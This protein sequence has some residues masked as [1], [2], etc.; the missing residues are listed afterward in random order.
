MSDKFRDAALE[1]H[2]SNP[3][4]KLTIQP[5]KPLANQS[6]LALAYSPG[7]AAACEAIIA[8]ENAAR[9]M[10]ARGN[11][12]AVV[13]N[14]TAVLGLGNI[15]PL[16]AKPVMEGKAVLFKKFAGIDAIDI[17]VN[18]NDPHKFI[19]IVEALE[20]SFG[21]INLED[22]KAPECFIVE[23][24]LR[25]RMKIP[26]FHD[27]QHG[28]AIIVGSAVLNWSRLTGRDLSKVKVV[29]SGAGAAAIACLNLL[30]DMGVQLENIIATD[31]DGVLHEGRANSLH[32]KQARFAR[33]LDERTL[34]DAIGGAD[35]F[36]GLSAPRVLKPEHVKAMADEPLILAL[37]N[38]TPEIMPDEVR[39]IRDDAYIATGRSDF[40]N[41]VNNVLC[42]P[43]IFRGALDVG[44][45]EINEEMKLAC[46]EA[47]ANLAMVEA[48][49]AV[50]AAYGDEP[51]KFGRDYLIPKPFD[52]RLVSRVAVAV[53]KAAMET[54]VAARPLEDIEGYEARLN[55]FMFKSGLVMTP[56]FSKAKTNPKRVAY[57]EGEDMR[58]LYAVQ[59]AVDGGLALPI[60]IGRR[61][62][63]ESRIDRHNLRIREGKHFDLVDPEDDPRFPEYWSLYHKL[64]ERKGITPARARDIVRTNTTVIAA[65]M[66]HK[67]EADAMICGVKGGYR[68]ALEDVTN[69]IG[70]QEGHCISAA[71]S[72]LVMSSGTY[73]MCDTHINEDPSASEVAEMTIEAA[74][75][76]RRFGIEPRVALLSYSNFGSRSGPSVQKMQEAMRLLQQNAPE[77]EV[78]GEMHGNI[79]LDDAQR[80]QVFPNSRLRG[81]AN[82]L[83]MP[84]L[85]AANIAYNLVKSL[86]DAQP[87]GPLL[88]GI[89]KPAHILTSSATARTILNV[90]ALAT[91][92]AQKLEPAAGQQE[93]LFGA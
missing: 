46:V 59:Q 21:A 26:V 37:A 78:E 4:G 10:T 90:T 80:E 86:T 41:Q 44:A 13:T 52:P 17:E 75:A 12:V 67:G 11:L 24:E 71:L 15:G 32:V 5:T 6:D 65:L 9:D 70:L 20:P 48:S 38:P 64:M 39:A 29:S 53:A 76:V 34:S 57:A 36:L 16:A 22:I 74:E 82:L 51:M 87:V 81:P 7:V 85:D 66:V 83:V 40:P 69:V 45:T 25:R 47:I 19:D 58:V 3:P 61:S 72:V 35:V 88:L 77:L 28:T 84:N 56:V 49:E 8:D 1:Y 63:V 60:L 18:A 50:A 27:D 33:K 30:V 93:A 54:G 68:S 55:R 2:R 73:F 91:V 62:V 31:I 89:G 79:A 92:D 43:F 23:E 14:G 42:F